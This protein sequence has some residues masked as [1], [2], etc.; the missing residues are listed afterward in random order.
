MSKWK[1]YDG[2]YVDGDFRVQSTKCLRFH[3]GTLTVHTPKKARGIL[4]F[5]NERDAISAALRLARRE[6]DALEKSITD[7]EMYLKG[8]KHDLSRALLAHSIAESRLEDLD[9]EQRTDT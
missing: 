2:W 1:L 5:L 3:T 6:M 8:K 4:G 9:G 7:T